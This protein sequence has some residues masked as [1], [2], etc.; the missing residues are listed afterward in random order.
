M[1]ELPEVEQ[2]ARVLARRLAG[3]RIEQATAD[4]TPLLRGQD[5]RAFRRA[6]AGRALVQSERRGKYLILSFDGPLSLLSHLGMTGKWVRRAESERAPPH[7]R[8]RLALSDGS[9]LYYDDQRMLGR[10]LVLPRGEIERMPEIA[11][12]GPDPVR[13]ALTAATLGARLGKTRRA[14]KVAL[15]DPTVIAGLGNIYAT[16]A[17]F[18]AGIH[19]ARPASS[20]SRVELGALAEAIREVLQQAFARQGEQDELTYVSAG[21]ENPFLVYDR[22][23]DPCPRCGDGIEK[24]VLGGR[25]SAFCPSCQRAQ[26]RRAATRSGP[27]RGR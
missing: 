21:G 27:G 6:L 11:E 26:R 2:Q 8:A 15:M 5:P 14:V 19:P 1:P 23:G 25:T 24:L 20:L 7:V 10:L 16:E 18:L 12:L 13:D 9:V 17:C 4:A 22:S 3:V